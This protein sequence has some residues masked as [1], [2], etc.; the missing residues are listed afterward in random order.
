MKK[1]LLLLF[2]LPHILF[3]QNKIITNDDGI[4]YSSSSKNHDVLAMLVN[5]DQDG[6]IDGFVE[7]FITPATIEI[8]TASKAMVAECFSFRFEC[9]NIKWSTARETNC[10]HFLIMFSRD[11]KNWNILGQIYG[12]GNSSV[13]NNYSYPTDLKDVFFKVYQIDFNGNMRDFEPVFG[14]CK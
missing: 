13:R 3:S 10:S 6:F 4:I 9:G 8:K 12:A 5:P 1:A 11:N 14:S 7:N 2:L